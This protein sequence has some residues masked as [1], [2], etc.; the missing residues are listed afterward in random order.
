MDLHSH[1]LAM[2]ERPWWCPECV[3]LRASALGLKSKTIE[4]LWQ[5]R[6]YPR[7]QRPLVCCNKHRIEAHIVGACMAG[8]GLILLLVAWLK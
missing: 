1:N 7:A 5:A 4:S 2:S 3:N 6:L 8:A